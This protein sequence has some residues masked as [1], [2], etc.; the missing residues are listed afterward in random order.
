MKPRSDMLISK[1]KEEVYIQRKWEKKKSQKSWK[2]W[3]I[4]ST[5]LFYRMS[6]SVEP[7]Y[8]HIICI[9]HAIAKAPANWLLCSRKDLSGRIFLGLHLLKAIQSRNY[10]LMFHEVKILF[11]KCIER[12][13]L[14]RLMHEFKTSNNIEE[15]I[16]SYRNDLRI[17][18]VMVKGIS[19]AKG[20]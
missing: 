15:I 18:L 14:V 5:E 9:L 3:K 7:Q 12:L 17:R 13:Y 6:I 1:L 16:F 11:Y 8:L 20:S 10:I 4:I 2:T 19:L